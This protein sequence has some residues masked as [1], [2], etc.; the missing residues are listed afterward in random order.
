MTVQISP[1]KIR[2]RPFQPGNPG[3]PPG[4]KNKTTRLVEQLL[5]DEAEN[6]TRKLI[7]LAK[8]GNVGCLR[9]CIERLA[10]RRNGR[11]VD[12][13]L[14]AIK[15]TQDI[16]AAMA[17]ITT[18]VNNGSLSPEE[19]GSLVRVLEGHAKAI[20]TYDLAVRLDRLEA[21]LQGSS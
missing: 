4:A 7:E 21:Q 10:P 2:G 14:P 20:E 3:R 13:Q 19:A 15:H 9:D 18:A 8:N 5:S 6:L 12:F 11:P 1:K 16:V 17:A